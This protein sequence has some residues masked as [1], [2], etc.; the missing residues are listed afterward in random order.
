MG[1][2]IFGFLAY[3]IAMLVLKCLEKQNDNSSLRI[4]TYYEK[5]RQML[6]YNLIVS[7]LTESYAIISVC[8]MINLTNVSFKSF[9]AAF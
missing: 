9:G 3:G 4:E 7:I 2:L 5:L 1:S 8:C 6:F